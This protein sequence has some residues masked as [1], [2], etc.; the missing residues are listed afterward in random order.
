[1]TVRQ[2]VAA[3]GAAPLRVEAGRAIRAAGN[4]LRDYVAWGPGSGAKNGYGREDQACS[5][6]ARFPTTAES[7]RSADDQSCRHR[8]I[9]NHRARA[10]ME[11]NANRSWTD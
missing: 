9:V 7:R 10:E 8:I 2:N 4:L 1:V 11:I 5:T 3:F 6:A